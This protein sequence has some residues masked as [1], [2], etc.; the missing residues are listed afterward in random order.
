MFNQLRATT[1]PNAHYAKKNERT[2][3]RDVLVTLKHRKLILS[4]CAFAVDVETAPVNIQMELIELRCNGTL[5]GNYDTVGPTKC[6]S[7]IPV[8]MPHFRQQLFL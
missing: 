5:K 6:I 2:S 7:F 1:F 3:L 4:C 8:T